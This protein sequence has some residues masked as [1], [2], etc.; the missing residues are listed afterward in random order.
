[1]YFAQFIIMIAASIDATNSSLEHVPSACDCPRECEPH[2]TAPNNP[3][4]IYKSSENRDKIFC[5]SLQPIRW[6]LGS[7]SKTVVI[8]IVSNSFGIATIMTSKFKE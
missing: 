2:E 6:T 8:Y 4:K 1:M 3:V 5:F 7:N